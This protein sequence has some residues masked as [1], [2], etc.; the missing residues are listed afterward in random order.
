MAYFRLVLAILIAS[1]VTI[2]IP[3][4]SFAQEQEQAWVVRTSGAGSLDIMLEQDW[5]EN[6]SAKFTVSF[7][8]PNTTTLHQHQDYDILIRQGDSQIFSAA[9]ATNQPLIHNVEGT[10]T[11]PREPFEFSNGDYTI[12]V[13]VLGLGFPPIPINPEVATFP[14]T[15][16]PEFPVGLTGLIAV[17][18]ASS[19]VM[20]RKF[21]L[22]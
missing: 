6:G 22:F 21:R 7:L 3:N 15:V 12:E 13:Q 14:I 18:V 9:G 4:N 17:V 20:T 5:T 2:A 11:V 10:T 19:I 16:V 1:V 8:N